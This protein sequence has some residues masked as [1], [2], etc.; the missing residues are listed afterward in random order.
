MKHLSY[1][2]TEKSHTMKK[3]TSNTQKIGEIGESLACKYLEKQG[4]SILERNYTKKWGE[5]DIIAKKK[6][7]THFIEVK[8][9][10]VEP[11]FFTYYKEDTGFDPKDNVHYWK[12]KKLRRTIES[13]LISQR[14]GN[15]EWQFDVAII[16]L[17]IEK[18]LGKVVLMENLIL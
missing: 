18:K 15:I 17:N 12:I 13:Y 9:K 5:I 3:F 10:T 14:F 11:A 8:S 4:F 16:Y 6:G 7:I 1:K 2:L